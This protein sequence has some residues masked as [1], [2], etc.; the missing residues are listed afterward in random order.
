MNDIRISVKP[1]LNIHGFNSVAPRSRQT[2]LNLKDKEFNRQKMFNKQEE[3]IYVN[4]PDPKSNYYVSEND[5]FTSMAYA[6]QEK[7]ERDSK[8]SA[9]L[10]FH[11]LKRAKNFEKSYQRWEKMDAHYKKN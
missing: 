8:H 2:R 3:R 10:N 4:E 9:K 7:I 11:E 1:N 5:R 6:K